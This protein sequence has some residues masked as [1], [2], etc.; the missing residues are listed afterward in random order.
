MPDVLIPAGESVVRRLSIK[1]FHR[2]GS[3]GVPLQNVQRQFMARFG[4]WGRRRQAGRSSSARRLQTNVGHVRA[5]RLRPQE[6]LD[7]LRA[8]SVLI[9]Q[10][11]ETIRAPI[12]TRLFVAPH[13]WRLGKVARILSGGRGFVASAWGRVR[14]TVV[15][16]I[17]VTHE[18]GASCDGW[19]HWRWWQL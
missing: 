13:W 16:K 5:G 12:P 1:L 4:G 19:Q 10:R 11:I 8:G 15:C 17:L 18:S 3:W 14:L 7:L 2:C 9:N 6:E